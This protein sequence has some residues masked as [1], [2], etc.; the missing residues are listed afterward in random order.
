MSVAMRSPLP[1]ELGDEQVDARSVHYLEHGFPHDL[2]R[3]HC[4]DDYEI[5]LIVASVGKLFCG[6]HIGA[7]GPGQLV[8]TGPGLPHNWISQVGDDE[9]F[10]L[11]D[12]VVQFRQ[13]LVQTMAACATELQPLLPLLERAR[14]G[15]EFRATSV[16]EA[17]PWF[18]RVRGASGPSR[19][20]LL[21]EFLEF[22][23]LQPDQ[24]L[25]STLPMRSREDASSLD[26][27]EK[28]TRYIA[29]N[30]TRDLQLADVST[31]T[32]M[33][34]SAFSR[35]FARETG[36]SFTR[37]LNRVRVSRACELL[38][39]TQEPITSICFAV[40]FNNVA[41]FNRRFRELKSVTPREYR[42]EAQLRK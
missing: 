29:D 30:Y 37:F 9:V 14:H 32:G 12:R 41:N 13:D 38:A 8:M 25:L 6:D 3:W 33:S 16:C 42:R 35:F 24:F 28:V 26:K 20:A 23:S 17:E 5:H 27:V 19:I 4:H 22:L 40:G 2:V 1:P 11:R 31:L 34:E 15:I 36:N 7:F 21:L 18:Q 39:D 10:E